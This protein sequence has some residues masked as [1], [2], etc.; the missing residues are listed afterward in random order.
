MHNLKKEIINQLHAFDEIEKTSPEKLNMAD[1]NT[2]YRLAKTF[3]YLAKAEKYMKKMHKKMEDEDED[4][5]Y[6][7]YPDSK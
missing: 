6:E 7:M 3:F 1:L 4:Y 2:I 5:D